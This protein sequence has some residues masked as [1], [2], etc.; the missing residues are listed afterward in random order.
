MLRVS[1]NV[2][3]ETVAREVCQFNEFSDIR[4]CFNWDTGKSF[5]E[6]KDMKGE[7]RSVGD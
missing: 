2:K 1:K 6:M 3:G 7:W 4:S 5:Q